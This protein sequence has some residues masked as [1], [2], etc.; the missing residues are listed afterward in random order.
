MANEEDSAGLTETENAVKFINEAVLQPDVKPIAGTAA[1]MVDQAVGMMVQ[2]LQSFLKGFEQIGLVALAKLANNILTYGN[3]FPPPG[4]SSTDNA[5]TINTGT[6]QKTNGPEVGQQAMKDL[7]SMV[8]EYG[9]QKAEVNALINSINSGNYNP[10]FESDEKE[11]SD[12]E[13]KKNS[14]FSGK[15]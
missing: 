15:K 4:A 10:V 8:G 13:K 1:P 3:Y 14:W 6:G 12:D 7:F 9:K 5:E 11:E 2:D